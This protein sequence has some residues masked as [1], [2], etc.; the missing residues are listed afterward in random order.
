MT[1]VKCTQ[2]QLQLTAPALFIAISFLT[3]AGLVSAKHCYAFS[4]GD[5]H[6]SSFSGTG[7]KTR[8]LSRSFS[9]ECRSY[10]H[11]CR[12][13]RNLFNV[14]RRT[15]RIVAKQLRVTTKGRNSLSAVR[16]GR[17]MG[18]SGLRSRL[19]TGKVTGVKRR[20]SGVARI[21]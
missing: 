11:A 3:L 4:G 16:Y 19:R 20:G 17:R 14:R 9:I 18:G 15:S 5:S 13:T 21:Y 10:T 8:V 12:S 1:L 7:S 2:R 6:Y